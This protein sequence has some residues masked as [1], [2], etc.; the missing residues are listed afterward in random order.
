[1]AVEEAEGCFC[2]CFMKQAQGEAVRCLCSHP[3]PS[4]LLPEWGSQVCRH[5]TSL[6]EVTRLHAV[7]EQLPFAAPEWLPTGKPW[8]SRRLVPTIVEGAKGS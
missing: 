7:C 5:C 1:M 8:K 6:T 2:L 3:A 4:L